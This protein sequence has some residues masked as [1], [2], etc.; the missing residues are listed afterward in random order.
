M[1]KTKTRWNHIEEN[2]LL[3]YLKEKDQYDQD[4]YNN[5]FRMFQID[6][7]GFYKLEFILVKHLQMSL[8]EIDSLEYYRL[9]Y[10]IENYKEYLE[11]E[12]R[13]HEQEETKNKQMY[14]PD[15][16]MS[17]SKSMTKGFTGMGGMPKMPSMSGLSNYKI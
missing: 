8:E 7:E 9:Q 1:T 4:L 10:L 17:D 14:N 6:L 5:L 16:M 13:Q 12:K 3:F 11:E 2:R 15:K